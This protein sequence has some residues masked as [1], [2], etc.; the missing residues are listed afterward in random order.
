MVD[1]AA[2]NPPS[3]IVGEPLPAATASVAKR[4]GSGGEADGLHGWHVLLGERLSGTVLCVDIQGG[5]TESFFSTI[6]ADLHVIDLAAARGSGADEALIVRLEQ[7][8]KRL[9]ARGFAGRFDAFVLHDLRGVL[10]NRRHEEV[11]VGVLAAVHQLLRQGG[12]CYLGFR[13]A[14][15]MSRARHAFLSVARSG[16]IG[17]GQLRSRLSKA[18]FSSAAVRMHPYLLDQDRVVQILAERG[19]VTVKN[20]TRWRERIK[21]WCYGPAGSR[22]MAPAYGVVAGRDGPVPSVIDRL[23]DKLQSLPAVAGARLTMMRCQVAPSKVF[24]SFGKRDEHHGRFVVIYARDTLSLARRE[25]EANLLNALARRLP[26]FRD[27][28][29]SP[30]GR[31]NIGAYQYFVL[32]ELPGMSI[33]GPYTGMTVATRNAAQVLTRLHQ[34]T[35]VRSPG[36]GIAEDTL[37]EIVES[38]IARYPVLAPQIRLIA[39]EV[40]SRLVTRNWPTVCE[41]G[42]YKLENV[43]LDPKS[44]QVFGIIDWELARLSGFPLIDLLYLIAYNRSVSQRTDVHEVYLSVLLPWKFGRSEAGLIDAYLRALGMVVDDT[45]LWA[46]VFMLHDIGVRWTFSLS[47]P[48]QRE[49]LERLL[50]ATARR[51][52]ASRNAGS[53]GK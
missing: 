6:A 46:A 23:A 16:L 53:A 11:M 21:E 28:L 48:A 13:N 9:L 44:L 2:G 26:E 18:G 19:Y 29:P 12:F 51:L 33:D 24:F 20:S 41:H 30:L 25:V 1:H 17:P 49:R 47:D 38:A 35:A 42:D 39:T 43:I 32:S 34:Q 14:W 45:V 4:R 15:A 52:A 50:D 10:V 31:G 5:N 27:L 36:M 8:L 37:A 22:R 40:G 7:E 3:D